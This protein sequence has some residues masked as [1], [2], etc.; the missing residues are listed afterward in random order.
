MQK[1]LVAADADLLTN[2]LDHARFTYNQVN[3]VDHHKLAGQFFFGLHRAG[4]AEA[5]AEL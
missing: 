5:T 1:P 4:N 2:L 3:D